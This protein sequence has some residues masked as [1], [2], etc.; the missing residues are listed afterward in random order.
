MPWCRWGMGWKETFSFAARL[1]LV[2]LVIHGCC[3]FAM[4]DVCVCSSWIV[5]VAEAHLRL[6]SINERSLMQLFF[7]TFSWLRRQRCFEPR[8]LFHD[9]RARVRLVQYWWLG[10]TRRTGLSLHQRQNQGGACVFWMNLLWMI[11]LLV[12][13]LM[14]A[15][16]LIMFEPSSDLTLSYVKSHQT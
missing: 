14:C 12:A 1:A 11:D 13:Y 6:F 3:F 5:V 7:L 4:I 9:Q 10:R 2:C 15:T 8:K 16:T